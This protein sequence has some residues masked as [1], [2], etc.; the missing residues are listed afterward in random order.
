MSRRYPLVDSPTVEVP[1]EY[2]PVLL[3]VVHAV[4]AVQYY[5]GNATILY[6]R[7]HKDIMEDNG[8]RAWNVKESFCRNRQLHFDQTTHPSLVTT[9]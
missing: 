8:K 9:P 1:L 4:V 7:W 3:R 2:H 5:E 6:H